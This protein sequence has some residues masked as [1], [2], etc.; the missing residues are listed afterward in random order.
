MN[1]KHRIAAAVPKLKVADVPYNTAEIIRLTEEA[2]GN[3]A[4]LILFPAFALTGATCGDLFHLPDLQE[5][6][7]RSRTQLNS[8]LPLIL[9]RY[10]K[11]I[12]AVL[13]ND[14]LYESCP[15]GEHNA[16]CTGKRPEKCSL[17]LFPAVEPAGPERAD[18]R[19]KY[20]SCQ[21]GVSVF[22]SAG[23]YESTTDGVCDG[24]AMIWEEGRLL[25]ES[26]RFCRESRIIY[27][28]VN[29]DPED[30][31]VVRWDMDH[32]PYQAA[33]AAHPFIP[34]DRDPVCEE[35]FNIQVTGLL[36]RLEAS[37]SQRAVIGISG[38]LDSTLA[39]LVTAEAVK[40]LGWAPDRLIAITMP[41]FGTTN[42]TKSNSE[43]LS[44][45]LGCD[46]R[47]VDITKACLQHFEDI[48]HD[49]ADLSV[50]YQNVQAR[51]RTQILMDTANR[52]GGIVVG[53]GDLSEIA[54]GWSTYNGDHM[55]MY[56]VNCSIPKTLIRV[57]TDWYADKTG[58]EVGAV[59][60]DVLATPISPELLPADK[61]GN[62]AQE[63]ESLLGPYELHDFFLYHFILQ[64]KGLNAIFSAAREAFGTKYTVPEILRVLEI[65]IKR[66]FSQ[67]FKRSCSP[68]GPNATGLSLSPRKGGWTMPSDAAA[69][70]WLCELEKIRKDQGEQ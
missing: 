62:I 67:Q 55:S 12:R 32:A 7:R 49:P 39:I 23:I 20:L 31:T 10:N 52:E 29:C 25:A 16:P 41:G 33:D 22:A 14:A 38:G 17:T 53:T 70:V 43:K 8:V 27:A 45:L 56:N 68:D 19:K 69:A 5:S 3:G 35:I 65:F 6:I 34:A 37:Y 66:F 54:L 60:K 21:T 15:A 63:T 50:T 61:D 42:R 11:P 1:E 24:H 44:E 18:N 30:F 59:L 28:D 58:G 36:R 40:R 57:M 13:F 47:T 64:R 26:E 48:G 4:E 51:E 9:T 2:A 46:L